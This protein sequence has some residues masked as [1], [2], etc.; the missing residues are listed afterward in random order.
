MQSFLKENEF[1]QIFT[2]CL[3]GVASESGAEVFP[4][5][6]FDRE[7]FLRQDP[8]LHRQLAIAGGLEKVYDIGPAWRA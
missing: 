2:P 1:M 3:M 6:Y 8:Q 7:A 5:I 4:V